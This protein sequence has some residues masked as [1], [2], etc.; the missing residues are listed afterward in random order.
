MSQSGLRLG[1]A[2]PLRVLV[3]VIVVVVVPPPSVVLVG[4]L[5][6]LLL[7]RVLVE[8]PLP[9]GGAAAVAVGIRRVGGAV[10]VVL[11][12]VLPVGVLGRVNVAY[13]FLKKKRL[14]FCGKC[15][16]IVYI[17]LVPA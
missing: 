12:L 13:I 14:R 16:L 9:R 1:P 10:V 11:V 3:V 2:L 6:L 5:L 4:L 8:W 15:F 17:T 7:V